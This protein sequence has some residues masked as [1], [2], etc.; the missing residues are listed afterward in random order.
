MR[1]LFFLTALLCASVMAFAIDSEYCGQIMLQGDPREAAFTWETN[2]DGSIVISIS[3]TLGGAENATFF[4]GHGITADKIKIGENR[5]ALG[6]YFTH[7]GE[8]AGQQSLILTLTN[9]ANAPAPGTKIYV[10]N[11]VV[12]YATSKDGNAWPYLTFEYSYGGVCDA[13]PVLTRIDLKASSYVPQ[14]GEA[15]TLTATPRDQ[16]NKV[17][18]ASVNFSVSP[19][20]AGSFV[21]NVFTP[22]KLCVATITATSGEVSKSVT[23][24]V[25][26]SAN[27]A[28]EKD[29]EAGFEPGGDGDAAVN[30]NDGNE[31]TS[32]DPYSNRPYNEN[33]WMVDLG[34]KYNIELINVLWGTPGS[35]KYL[36]QVRDE[37]PSADDKKDD[38]AWTPITEITEAGNESEQFVTTTATGRYLRLQSVNATADHFHLKEVRVFGTVWT[39][40]EDPSDPTAIDN[41][42]AGEKAVKVIENGQMIIIKNG[43]RYN[44]QGAVVK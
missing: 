14:V 30:V 19:A 6:T 16:M 11:Q 38:N 42:E 24:Y 34:A 10:E 5:D 22:A 26:P 17:I 29:C 31:S 43:V 36:L 3:E 41:I 25:V 18:E 33:W 13:T 40:P 35:T 23:I 7:P 44:A 15:I 39:E 4:R 32:W 2:T 20:D 21:G 1:K 37:A 9:P 8:I 12:E 28:F 27:L